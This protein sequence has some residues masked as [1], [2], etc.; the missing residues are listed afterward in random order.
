M[1]W[2]RFNR[3]L[4]LNTDAVAAMRVRSRRSSTIPPYRDEWTVQA[5]AG[6]EWFTLAVAPTEPDAE[7]AMNVLGARFAVHS[8]PDA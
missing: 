3:S 6:G 1:Y 5:L 4:L 2:E 7:G 8:D